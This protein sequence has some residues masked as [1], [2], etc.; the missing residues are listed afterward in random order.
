MGN[1]KAPSPCEG[2][3]PA[4]GGGTLP[5]DTC[6]R[7]VPGRACPAPASLLP[8][9]FSHTGEGAFLFSRRL[10]K[11]YKMKTT[12]TLLLLLLRILHKNRHFRLAKLP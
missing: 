7:E 8:K 5:I 11:S 12:N 9:P 6:L 10:Q 4:D 1:P 3:P 2:A